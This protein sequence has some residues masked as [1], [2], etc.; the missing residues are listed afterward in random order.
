MNRGK[1]KVIV[2]SKHKS[3]DPL[4]IKIGYHKFEVKESCYLGRYLAQV[5]DAM[6]Q[7]EKAFSLYH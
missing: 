7:H 3:T 1:T 6:S 4:S 5:K 2:R